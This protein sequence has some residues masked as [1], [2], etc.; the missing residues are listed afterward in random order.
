MIATTLQYLC[1]LHPY[2]CYLVHHHLCSS[3]VRHYL[4]YK[5][6]SFNC[7]HSYYHMWKANWVC[8]YYLEHTVTIIHSSKLTDNSPKPKTLCR[9]KLYLSFFLWKL[10]LHLHYF[11][12]H[13]VQYQSQNLC[14]I[15]QEN[16]L[17]GQCLHLHF[18]CPWKWVL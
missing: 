14:C 17:P 3:V 1:F 15:F 11:L 13:L 9:K 16:P 4:E 7:D 10:F 8:L 12:L 6:S 5:L 18:L 2:G